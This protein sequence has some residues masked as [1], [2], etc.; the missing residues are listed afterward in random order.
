MNR[1]DFFKAA[2]ALTVASAVWQPMSLGATPIAWQP[3]QLP[4]YADFHLHALLKP[5]Y[6]QEKRNPWV[7][8]DND[9]S[10]KL[11]RWIVNAS[12]S[13]RSSQ[14]HFESLMRGN[15][16]L[17]FV[18]IVPIERKMMLM[19]LVNKRKK[20]FNSFSCATGAEMEIDFH[21]L[22]KHEIEYDKELYGHIEL[23]L[24]FEKEP[25]LVNNR[26]CSY[27]I[28]RSHEHL[29]QLLLDPDK[30]AVVVNV[31]GGHA[32]AHS[33]DMVDL[34]DTTAY[35]QRILLNI[36]KLKGLKTYD[37]ACGT[38][39]FAPF[40]IGLNHFFW[41]GLCGH[42]RTVTNVQSLV[43]NQ[44]DHLNE[45]MQPL[46]E[47]CINL[48]LDNQHGRRILVD[49]KH[50]SWEGR[51]W[52]YQH[53]RERRAA[54]DDVPVICTHTAIA[55]VSCTDPLWLEKDGD[56]KSKNTFLD[57]WTINLCNE[58]IQAIHESKGMIGIMLD[59][60]KLCGKLGEEMI[61]KTYEGS[62]KRRKVYV[63]IIMANIL[64]AVRA[65]NQASAWD[66]LCIGSDFDGLI[67]PFEIY[68]RSADFPDLAQ[69]IHDFLSAPW[70]IEHFMDAQSI[71]KLKFGLSPQSL[72]EKIMFSNL[73][74]F[75][76]RQV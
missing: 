23:L 17:A 40:S 52:Y 48:L 35:R 47:Q 30:L 44:K 39:D 11:A 9:C 19:P 71:E 68:N 51:Q 20:G 69:D 6:A 27:E 66:I 34:S 64:A 58:D 65:V 75:T 13:P 36:E 38:L 33:I 29:Q 50:M 12:D 16:R 26:H 57:P 37:N 10:G 1:K 14:C 45:G 15:V 18:S 28:V 41:N 55:G 46:G 63:S 3:F 2:S 7:R 53:L 70:D 54:G 22:K 60:F 21:E 42:A 67:R 61:K 31:E 73:Q 32:L 76:M 8:V 56:K 5:Y 24:K 72:T 49:I 25:F 4:S 74:T 59:R 43:I 62:A